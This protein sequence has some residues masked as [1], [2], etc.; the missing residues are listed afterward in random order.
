MFD[1]DISDLEAALFFLPARMGG[2]GIHDPVELCDVDFTSSQAGATVISDVVRGSAAFDWSE[3]LA[4]VQATSVSRHQRVQSWYND[5]LHQV[6]DQ[7]SEAC[8]CTIRHSVHGWWYLSLQLVTT[9][10][11]LGALSF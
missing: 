1:G 2:L 7:F 8:Q 3:H 5:S 9:Y 6:M 11:S 10:F 4:R